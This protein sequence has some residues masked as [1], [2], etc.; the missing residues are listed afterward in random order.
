MGRTGCPFMYVITKVSARACFDD[1]D[2]HMRYVKYNGVR[3][4]MFDMSPYFF[5]GFQSVVRLVCA[6]S[7]YG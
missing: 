4:V 6:V 3:L 7:V 5:S 1:G 2:G